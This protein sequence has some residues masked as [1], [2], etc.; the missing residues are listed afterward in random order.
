MPDKLVTFGEQT[1]MKILDSLS[2]PTAKAKLPGSA[3]PN[4]EMR[5]AIMRVTSALTAAGTV[6]STLTIGSGSAYMCLR[7]TTTLTPSTAVTYTVYNTHNAV[8]PVDTWINVVK[9]RGD[10]Y[11]AGA[12]QYCP[13]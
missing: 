6:G 2:G 11:F 9:F 5:C 4:P 12:I 7:T 8:I 10:W 13:S 1:S 3:T